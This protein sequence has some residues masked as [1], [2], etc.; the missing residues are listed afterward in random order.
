MK[1]LRTVIPTS[2]TRVALSEEQV[3]QGKLFHQQQLDVMQNRMADI[4]EEVI[5]LTFSENKDDKYG[6]QLAYLQGQLSIISLQVAESVEANHN[7]ISNL[8]EEDN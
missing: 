8:Q 5:N 4:A 7:L 1:V 3:T 6:L 2:F